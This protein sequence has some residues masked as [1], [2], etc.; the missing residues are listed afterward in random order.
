MRVEQGYLPHYQ[1]CAGRR[2][3]PIKFPWRYIL[4]NRTLFAVHQTP[5]A[6]EPGQSNPLDGRSVANQI[7]FVVGLGQSNPLGGRAW[8]TKAPWL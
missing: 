4:V 1:R 6:E 3:G 8:S 2:R 5:L 7:A